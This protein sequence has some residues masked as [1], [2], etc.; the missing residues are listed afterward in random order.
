M[1]LIQVAKKLSKCIGLIGNLWKENQDLRKRLTR[2]E[3]DH[4]M[5][6][7]D[8]ERLY[9]RF[10]SRERTESRFNQAIG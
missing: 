4:M 1:Q 7:H 8:L 3:T 9:R 10:D 5:L 2:M 6:S